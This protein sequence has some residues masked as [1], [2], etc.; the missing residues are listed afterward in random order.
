MC[1]WRVQSRV[2]LSLVNVNHSAGRVRDRKCPGRS[3]DPGATG[4]IAMAH[5]PPADWTGPVHTEYRRHT[6]GYLQ[7]LQRHA[8]YSGSAPHSPAMASPR[9]PPYATTK[10]KDGEGFGVRWGS[11][12]VED[13]GWERVI[14]YEPNCSVHLWR[15]MRL[16]GEPLVEEPWGG[17]VR[18]R[19]R[20]TRHSSDF[21]DRCSQGLDSER[22]K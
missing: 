14:Q 13:T 20:P 5:S 3:Q 18:T 1:K 15:R 2:P 19:R 17:C 9:T 10:D 21:H 4:R 8:F 12:R 7:D 22:G 6:S 16:G 11:M